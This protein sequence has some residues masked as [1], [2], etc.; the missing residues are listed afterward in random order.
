M[1]LSGASKGHYMEKFL[2]QNAHY[3]TK[4]FTEQVTEY[5]MKFDKE[6]DV[7]FPSL[8]K[9]RFV[10]MRNPFTA[11]AQMLQ[12]GTGTQGKLVKFQYDGFCTRCVF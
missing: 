8:G 1:S 9:G 11:N 3:E 4:S 12:T 6:I 7:H 2:S 10:Y 5:L